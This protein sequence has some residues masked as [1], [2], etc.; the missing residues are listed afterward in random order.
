MNSN[1]FL[2]RMRMRYANWQN[3]QRIASLTRQVDAH[4]ADPGASPGPGHLPVLLFNASTRLTGLSLN[5]SFQLLTGWMLRLVGVPV[6]HFACQ[7]GLRPCVL[8]TNRQDYSAFPPCSACIAQSKRLYHGGQVN[9]FT[10]QSDPALADALEKLDVDQLS[11][12]EWDFF[13]LADTEQPA[14]NNTVGS[15]R[16]ALRLPL[17]RLVLPSIRWALRRHQLPD[18]EPTRYLLRQYILSAHRVA[19]EYDAL[20][21][22][23]QP[24]ATLIFNGAMYPESTALWVARQRGLPAYTHEVGFQRLS[25]FFTNGDATAYPMDIPDDFDLDKEQNDRLDAYLEKRFQGQFTMAGIRFWPEMRGLDESFLKKMASFRQTVPVFTNVV[26]DTSQVFA[27]VIFPH[28]FAWLDLVLE[29]IRA[30]PE[31]LFVL[32]AHPDEMRPDSAK[33]S[34]QSVRDWVA[35]NRVA[36]LPN[37]VFI[38]SQEYISSY[39]LV[40]RSKFVIVYNSSI[41][42]EA[43]L[44]GKAVV[45][46]GKARYT[47]V[48]IVFFPQ[49]P[50]A[51]SRQLEQFLSSDQVELPAEFGRNARRFLYFQL[52]RA[53]LPLDAFLDVGP[54]QGFVQLKS[55]PWQALLPENSPTMRVLYDGLIHAQPFLL[56]E[57]PFRE[58]PFRDDPTRNRQ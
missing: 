3:K 27:N 37:V 24:A 28:M 29:V 16:R 42:L 33:K 11:Q 48:P 13:P 19:C 23:T 30:H 49:T 45:C 7:S 1:T 54:R 47:Q 6:I 57:L 41:G 44:L 43:T 39:E 4:A 58:L 32:R 21:D 22:K 40:Q 5:A 14:T 50:Q 18:D 8:G 12:V 15:H 20:I 10:F 38:D 36:E 52:Y 9:G 25:T 46:G 31:T 53:S 34:N 35:S 17:G 56:T 51:L 55:F 2:A 26:Y